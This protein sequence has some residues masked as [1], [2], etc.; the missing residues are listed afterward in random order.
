[1]YRLQENLE[2]N[3][4]T[5]ASRKHYGYLSRSSLAL[6]RKSIITSSV[7]PII[8]ADRQSRLCSSVTKPTL[9]ACCLGDGATGEEQ[10][11][12]Y[13]GGIVSLLTPKPPRVNTG[14]TFDL[15]LTHSLSGPARKVTTRAISSGKPTRLRGEKLANP[16]SISS[17][18]MPGWPPGT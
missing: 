12:A 15:P 4:R 6:T 8:V 3:L 17:I 9:R 16:L 7:L 5:K 14:S 1:M 13:N 11:L 2:G 18:S 10:H